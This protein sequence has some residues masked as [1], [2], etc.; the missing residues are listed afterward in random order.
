ACPNPQVIEQHDAKVYGTEPPGT[1]PMTVPH[2]DTRYLHHQRTFLFGTFAN[3]VPKYLT[4][5]STLDLFTSIQSY[6]TTT[7]FA[8]PVKH[9][10]L[11]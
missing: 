8:A 11:I 10:P 5:A 6:N 7:L 2:L 1:P 9:L 4:N 3:V